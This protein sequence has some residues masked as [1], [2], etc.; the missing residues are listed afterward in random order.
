MTMIRILITFDILLAD[1]QTSM[2]TNIGVG[3]LGYTIVILKNVFSFINKQ[4][5]N[6]LQ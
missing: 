6:M 3:Y 2:F 1:G 5:P 4:P